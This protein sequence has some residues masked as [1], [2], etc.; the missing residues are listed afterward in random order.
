MHGALRLATGSSREFAAFN[1][2][3]DLAGFPPR[4]LCRHQAVAANLRSNRSTPDL[5]L[6]EIG[7][8]AFSDTDAESDQLGVSDDHLT[9]L[10]EGNPFNREFRQF[11]SLHL[12][13]PLKR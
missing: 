11:H 9:E 4:F 6:C 7:L 1:F 13:P 2:G 5:S 10:H 3:E 12:D 8:R